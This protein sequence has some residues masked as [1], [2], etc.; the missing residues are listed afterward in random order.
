LEILDLFFE[1]K[2]VLSG[3]IWAKR[4]NAISIHAMAALTKLGLYPAS[5]R[6]TL[7]CVSD[8]ADCHNE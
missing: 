3:Q 2:P 8:T 5:N 4:I 7:F 1:I 6:V